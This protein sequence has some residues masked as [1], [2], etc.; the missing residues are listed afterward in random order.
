MSE[1]YLEL[2]KEIINLKRRLHQVECCLWEYFDE[3]YLSSMK[4]REKLSDD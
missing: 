2:K 1:E 4:V 3:Q